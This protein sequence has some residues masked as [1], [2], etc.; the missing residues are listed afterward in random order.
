MIWLITLVVWLGDLLKRV[1][2]KSSWHVPAYEGPFGA[3]RA[4]FISHLS[5]VSP[6]ANALVAGLSIGDTSLLHDSLKDSMK[7]V[8]LTHLTAVS[9]ANCAI[10]VGCVYFLLRKFAMSRWIR[11]FASTVALIFYVLLVGPQ[12]SVLRAATMALIVLTC[13]QL[14]RKVSPAHALGLSVML[15]L[16]VDPGLATN[17]GFQLSVL[18]TLGI[19]VVA[20]PLA[21]MLKKFVP[22]WLAIALAVSLAAQ[23]LCFPVL[24][25]LQP[26]LSTFSIPANLVAEPLVAPITVLGM[27]ACLIVPVAPWFTSFLTW[28]AS[29]GAWCVAS[30]ARFFADLPMATLAWPTG[31]LGI[32]MSLLLILSV[33]AVLLAR[34][35]PTRVL[36]GL[37]VLVFASAVLGGCAG[38]GIRSGSWLP[39]DWSIVSCDV[40]QGD[41]T[42]V[43]SEGYV[44][45]IDVGRKPGPIRSC[46]SLL[47]I[48]RVDLLVLTHFDLDHVGG[49]DGLLDSVSVDEALIT[50]FHDDRPAA[51]ITYRKLRIAASH[52]VEA[53][54]GMHGNLGRFSWQVLSPHLG[55]TEA[56]D[57]NDGSVTMLFSSADLILLTLADLGEK[58][59]MRLAGESADWLGNGF[60]SVPVVVKVSHHGSADQYA[61]LY[62][63]LKPQISLFSVGL[64]NDYGHPTRRTLDLLNRV[65]SREFRTD[66]QGS[67]AVEIEPEGLRVS[68]SGAG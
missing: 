1:E 21:I 7:I 42:V 41:A 20:P 32:V 66:R 18:A 13:L 52:M 67:I 19:L 3:L 46:I 53:G 8:S 59:Q 22:F 60:G 4:E 43:R 48:K 63:A 38:R 64:G 14:G 47:G 68:T 34:K 40:G 56:E 17:F 2:T 29:L 65:G 11:W 27:L 5:G 44:A 45:V 16:L 55:A 35:R 12:A 54:K 15:L 50:S 26:G 62:E 39:K 37:A 23:L 30:E 25:Q 49:L 61:E 57:S 51:A 6:D 9:G 24:L 10:V 58:G 33:L 36:G 31:T 28:F